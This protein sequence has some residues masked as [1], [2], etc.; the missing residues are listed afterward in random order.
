MTRSAIVLL[1]VLL[2]VFA[3]PNDILRGTLKKVDADKAVVTIT[4]DGKDKDF[5]VTADTRIFGAEKKPIKEAMATLK[6]GSPVMFK[7]TP[8][9]DSL[10]GIR[11][12]DAKGPAQPSIPRVDTSK[13]KP[14][15][16][17]GSDKYQGY[18]GGLYPNGENTRPAAHEKVGLEIAKSIRP[19]SSDGKPAADGKIV[20]LSVGMSNTS[21]ASEGFARLLRGD[22]NKNPALVFVNGAQGGMTAR[23][24][25][26]PDDRDSG[27]RYWTDSD[28]RLKQAGVTP[29]QVQA[30]WIKQADAGPTSGFPKYAQTL[31][32]ELRTIVQVIARRYPNCK[33]CYLS[34][35]TFGGYAKT[36][37][38]PEPYAYESAFS[39]KWLIEEQLKGD[40]D[41]N[42]DPA[43]GL[44]KAPW[45]SW[46]P[47][48]WAN[49]EKKRAD[50]FNWLETDS[51]ASDGTHESPSGQEKVGR[52]LL[53]FFTADSSGHV[54]GNRG[55]R[56][57]R[58]GPPALGLSAQGRPP[59]GEPFR[60]V[61]RL[62]RVFLLRDRRMPLGEFQTERVPGGPQVLIVDN[63]LGGSPVDHV[64]QSPQRGPAERVEPGVADDRREELLHVLP[65]AGRDAPEE[66]DT[67]VRVGAVGGPVG[68]EPVG[69]ELDF[70]RPRIPP[71]PDRE[72][73]PFAI[74]RLVRVAVERRAQKV[75]SLGR[76]QVRRRHDPVGGP[77]R[78]RDTVLLVVQLAGLAFQQGIGV[79]GAEQLRG[80]AE[81]E[82]HH[83]VV[84]ALISIP[85]LQIRVVARNLVPQ[86]R[87][88]S[89]GS[90][91]LAG[92]HDLGLAEERVLQVRGV[93]PP[94]GVKPQERPG[95]V[96]LREQ[97]DL[98]AQGPDVLHPVH[99][100]RR[101]AL[102]RPVEP[103]GEPARAEGPVLPP[104]PI[105]LEPVGVSQCAFALS[106][107][108]VQ[109]EKPPDAFADGLPFPRRPGLRGAGRR[110]PA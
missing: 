6:E 3:Q 69:E 61:G 90:E 67:P 25:Q 93:V 12:M 102:G 73:R 62:L 1:A 79:V 57:P 20:L 89:V 65:R 78:V 34:S 100:D 40:K 44:V 45:L 106:V 17:F 86:Q 41:L 66:R 35:R 31:Q 16:E 91:F 4:H 11:P 8:G 72:F 107:P 75:A 96:G 2:P 7:P 94:V 74:Q 39:V 10:V 52:E 43:K 15:T 49:G 46:G 50:G 63:R 9:G 99:R 54:D 29:L 101:R 88:Q 53:K 55:C 28:N 51:T 18:E 38:N 48:I 76:P 30:V 13:L 60:Q 5:K 80:V 104:G 21:Q 26:N 23:A 95:P 82:L 98:P 81:D 68:V 85:G 71:E 105:V 84:R 110:S 103:D 70:G 32:A 37:L 42:Y 109:I 83:A 14:L 58:S 22:A 64:H 77:Q 36:P 56:S 59:L 108:L 47:Y 87:Q 27:N 92:G 24:I 97:L 33:L 19:L